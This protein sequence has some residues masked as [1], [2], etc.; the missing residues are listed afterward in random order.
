MW[1]PAS[2]ERSKSAHQT[3]AW[4]V[5]EMTMGFENIPLGLTN[6]VPT[7]SIVDKSKVKRAMNECVRMSEDEIFSK[8]EEF[9]MSSVGFGCVSRAK[10]MSIS[11]C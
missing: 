10:Q 2:T 4:V 6:S 7:P 1:A 3:R 11:R 8:R 5:K 9:V